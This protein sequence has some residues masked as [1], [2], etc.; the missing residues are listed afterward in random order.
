MPLYSLN[1]FSSTVVIPRQ[2][3]GSLYMYCDIM[4]SFTNLVIE[5]DYR[6]NSADAQRQTNSVHHLRLV[7]SD[8]RDTSQVTMKLRSKTESVKKEFGMH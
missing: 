6:N 4:T 1:P 3:L 2:T 7:K 8:W 5:W